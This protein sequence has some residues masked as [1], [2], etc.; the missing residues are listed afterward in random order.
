MRKLLSSL[1]IIS[2]TF[3]S[4]SCATHQVS[5]ANGQHGGSGKKETKKEG[6][7][8]VLMGIGFAALLIGIGVGASKGE[9]D[10]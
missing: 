1:L 5:E 8:E 2:I 4:V 9:S 10:E 6:V 7:S 3:F